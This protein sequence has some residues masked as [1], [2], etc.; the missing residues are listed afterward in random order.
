M[1]ID[2]SALD[3]SSSD[4]PEVP[5]VNVRQA[6]KEKPKK[7]KTP[8][9][10]KAKATKPKKARK[11]LQKKKDLLDVTQYAAHAVIKRRKQPCSC[12]RAV[13]EKT[14]RRLTRIEH[15]KDCEY[16]GWKVRSPNNI[17]T[18]SA[19]RDCIGARYPAVSLSSDF[20]IALN[21]CLRKYIEDQTEQCAPYM[22]SHGGRKL[23]KKHF[24]QVPA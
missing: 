16:K 15:E 1:P 21:G 7:K 14:G 18:G 4:E 2:D 23:G 12:P 17:I 3:Q 24:E 11:A 10:H 19:L 5:E 22:R 8:K 13:S 9:T 20:P 6:E